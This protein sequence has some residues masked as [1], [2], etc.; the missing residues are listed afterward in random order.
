MTT[1]QNKQLLARVF[2]ALERGD[3]AP[4]RDAMADDV[5]WVFPGEWSWAG[6]WEPKTAVLEDLLRPLMRQ[7][8]SYES[9]AELIIAEGDRVVVQARSSAVTKRGDAYKQT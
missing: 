9:R 1:E 6:S 8:R 7:F 5:R 3:R 2:A 4:F